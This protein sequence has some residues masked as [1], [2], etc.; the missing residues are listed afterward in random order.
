ME[1]DIITMQEVFVF[2][3]TEWLPTVRAGPLPRYGV[4]P[5]FLERIRTAGIALN[6]ALFDPN[7]IY[8]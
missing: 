8:E 6:D 1:G 5:R 4:R 2:Q 7:R 3:Q